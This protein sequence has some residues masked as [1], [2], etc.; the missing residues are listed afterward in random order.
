[1]DAPTY[2][3]AETFD[4]PVF[5]PCVLKLTEVSLAELMQLPAAWEIIIKHLPALKFAVGSPQLRPQLGNMNVLSLS[6]FINAVGSAESLADI[7]RELAAL[8]P[9]RGQE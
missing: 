7:D 4:P 2:L 9:L 8:P 6:T 1:M 5:P 3:P